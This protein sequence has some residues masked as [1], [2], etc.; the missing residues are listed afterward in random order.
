MYFFKNSFKNVPGI[1][2]RFSEGIIE[3]TVGDT[4]EGIKKIKKKEISWKI[5]WR[6]PD[7]IKINDFFKEYLS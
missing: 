6:T 2:R 7:E 1:P 4:S 5:P 3:R